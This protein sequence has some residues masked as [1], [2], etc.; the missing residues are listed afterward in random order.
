MIKKDPPTN[1]GHSRDAGLILGQEHSPEEE[2][3]SPQYSCLEN[4]MGREAWRAMVRR[5][6]KDSDTTERLSMHT[7]K[8]NCYG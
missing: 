4:P 1:A 5:V 8:W 7:K 6:S 3:A 2:M